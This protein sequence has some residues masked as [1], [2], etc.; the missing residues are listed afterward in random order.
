MDIEIKD[1]EILDRANQFRD[2]ADILKQSNKL[3]PTELNACLACESMSFTLGKFRFL[4]RNSLFLQVTQ[5]FSFLS[6]FI[7]YHLTKYAKCAAAFVS[8]EF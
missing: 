8:D 2:A 1:Y 7:K 3:I 4:S 6:F 5:I